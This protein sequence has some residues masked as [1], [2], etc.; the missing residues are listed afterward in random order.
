MASDKGVKGLSIDEYKLLADFY[1]QL[2]KIAQAHEAITAK[3]EALI[4]YITAFL[5]KHSKRSAAFKAGPLKELH[6]L[7][8]IK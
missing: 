4:S 3:N 5:A 2:V 7:Q 8:S 1:G 6:D